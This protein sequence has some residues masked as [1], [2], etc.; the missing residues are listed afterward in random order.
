MDTATLNLMSRLAR[1]QDTL[2][3]SPEQLP[4]SLAY[5]ELKRALA[6]QFQIVQAFVNV[7]FVS[8]DPYADSLQMFG[9][10]RYRHRLKVY[11]GAD[12]PR[13]HPL[14]A[15]HPATGQTYNVIFRTV[16]D[17]LAH[18]PERLAFGPIGEFRAFQAHARLLRGNT[19]AI[20]ALATETLGANAWFNFGPRSHETPKPFAPQVADLLPWPMIVEA[21]EHTP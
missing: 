10:I 6:D 19:G 12:M 20:H 18:Y 17:A 13:T 3:H 15:T 1:A 4:I 11:I 9:D 14:A 7:E 16:H 8:V 5:R 2:V 21:L